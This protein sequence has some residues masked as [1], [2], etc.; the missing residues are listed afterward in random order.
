MTDEKDVRLST[1]TFREMEGLENLAGLD[2]LGT[3]AVHLSDGQLSADFHNKNG[4]DDEL[5]AQAAELSGTYVIGINYE[6]G[7]NAL[8]KGTVRGATGTV[9]GKIE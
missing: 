4:V 1:Q 7:V 6:F 3:A 8:G 2:V 9:Y 5:K